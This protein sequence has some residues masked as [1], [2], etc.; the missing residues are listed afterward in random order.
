M[1]G[2]RKSR[3]SAE[4]S[5]QMALLPRPPFSPVWPQAGTLAD[6][7]LEILLTGVRLTHPRFEALSFSWRLAA[8]VCD[9]RDLGWLVESVEVSAPTPATPDRRIAEYHL[10]ADVRAQA[11]LAR[12][13]AA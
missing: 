2:R 3:R 11:L 8:V 6:R 7:C 4:N 13:R 10:P 5:A 9:L 12:R 1:T